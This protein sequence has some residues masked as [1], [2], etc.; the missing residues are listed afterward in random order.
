MCI[1][2]S[3]NI[4]RLWVKVETPKMY[5]CGTSDCYLVN[6]ELKY[7]DKMRVPFGMVHDLMHSVLS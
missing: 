5:I 7:G 4:E 1:N 3:D 6:S 2:F